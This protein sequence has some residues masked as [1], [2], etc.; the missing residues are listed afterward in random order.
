MVQKSVTYFMDGPK[1]KVAV[2]DKKSAVWY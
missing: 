2:K 1:C